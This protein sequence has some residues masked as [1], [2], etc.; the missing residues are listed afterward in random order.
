MW[1]VYIHFSAGKVKTEKPPDVDSDAFL[2]LGNHASI[3]FRGHSVLSNLDNAQRLRRFPATACEIGDIDRSAA[4][5]RRAFGKFEQ[6]APKCCIIH[7]DVEWQP[8]L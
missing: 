2:S 1:G 3:T 7:I 5:Q 6:T 4:V 8:I